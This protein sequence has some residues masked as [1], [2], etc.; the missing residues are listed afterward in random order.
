MD[1]CA[2]FLSLYFFLFL[3]NQRSRFA[4][5]WFNSLNLLLFICPW[6]CRKSCQRKTQTIRN[7]HDVN[8]EAI[9]KRQPPDL[10]CV[11]LQCI[12]F[13]KRTSQALGV[14]V[15]RIRSLRWGLVLFLALTSQEGGEWIEH[16]VGG[17]SLAIGTEG[18][19]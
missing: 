18:T 16:S 3:W 2:W 14:T 7:R 5:F 1:T 8:D 19:F 6:Y 4:L 15:S 10:Q 13:M 9:Q 17:W 12:L 11:K